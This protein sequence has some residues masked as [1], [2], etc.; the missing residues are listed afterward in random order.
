VGA[1]RHG[2]FKVHLKQ[3]GSHGGLP[4]MDFYNVRRDPGERY[5]EFYP[6]LYAITPIQNTLKNHTALIRKFPHRVPG[7]SKTPNV[8]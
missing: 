4:K 7:S 3:G 2:N 5:G 6:G 8:S 1:I